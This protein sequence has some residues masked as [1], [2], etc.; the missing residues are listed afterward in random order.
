MTILNLRWNFS[1]RYQPATALRNILDRIFFRRAD[2][3]V[4]RKTL[5]SVG[6][7]GEQQQGHRYL[8]HPQI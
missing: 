1:Y 2:A 3:A 4:G 8:H 6:K 5:P 7:S